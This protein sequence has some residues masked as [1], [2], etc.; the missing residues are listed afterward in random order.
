MNIAEVPI[1]IVEDNPIISAD[2]ESLLDSEGFNILGVAHN[3]SEAFDY[4]QF[5]S[6]GFSLLDVNLGTGQT[7]LDIAK[8]IDE[9]YNIPY[10]FLTSFD[11]ELTINE[12]QNLSPYGYIVKPF[13]ERTLLTT[14]KLA[15]S[16]HSKIVN[17]DSSI[18][19]LMHLVNTPLSNQEIKITKA[20][21][22]GKSYKEIALDLFV[23]INTIKYHAKNIYMKFEIKSRAEL[24]ALIR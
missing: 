5:K 21:I 14:I 19:H 9:K 15:I 24:A 7:G 10:V 20:L 13:Q 18:A 11:D 12:A 4:L 1:L 6:V 23:S 22:S 2:I 17:S 3:A 8:V 16:N